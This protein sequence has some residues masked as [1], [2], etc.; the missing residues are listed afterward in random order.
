MQLDEVLIGMCVMKEKTAAAAAAAAEQTKDN[1]VLQELQLRW[2]QLMLHS[3]HN[4][5]VNTN[6]VHAGDLNLSLS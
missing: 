4:S 6:S 1:Q 3:N 5:P 2:Q